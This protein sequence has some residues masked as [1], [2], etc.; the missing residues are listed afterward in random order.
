MFSC[1]SRIVQVTLFEKQ[2]LKKISFP[3][4]KHGYLIHTW[5]DK[6]FMCTHCDLKVSQTPE[7]IYDVLPIPSKNPELTTNVS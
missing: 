2:Q 6:A 7:K 1:R 5:S 4:N 3:N